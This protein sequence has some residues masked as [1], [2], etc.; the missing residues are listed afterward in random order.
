MGDRGADRY[1]RAEDVV[2][3]KRIDEFINAQLSRWPLAC[4]NFRALKQVRV[5]DLSVGGLDVKVQF[6]PARI[7]SSAAKTDAASLRARP[8]FLC[9]GNRPEEQIHIRFDGRKGKRQ[10]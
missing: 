6:N 1:V 4:E 5:K 7:V 2:N 10:I 9:P 8:C 3:M